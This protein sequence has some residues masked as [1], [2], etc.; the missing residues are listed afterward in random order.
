[1]EQRVM[2]KKDIKSFIAE[3]IK[4]YPAVYGPV[5]KGKSVVFD[6][7][8][9]AGEAKFSYTRSILPPKKYM[10]PQQ[11]CIMKFDMPPNPKAGSVVEFEDQVIVG[12]HPCDIRAIKL[13]DMIMKGGNPDDNYNKRRE[14]T[15][16]I[17]I[18]CVPDQYC[19]CSS[20]MD[21][22][23]T[24]GFDI[25]LTDLGDQVLVDVLTEKGKEIISKIET[26]PASSTHLKKQD[27]LLEAKKKLFTAKFTGPAQLL[28]LELEGQWEAPVWEDMGKKC[29]SCGQCVLVCP[30]CYCFDV[31]DE[32]ALSMKKGNRVRKWD[33]CQLAGFAHVGSGENFREEPSARVR[34]RYHR[35]FKYH[36]DSHST[37][38]CTGCGRC[39]VH[40]PVEINLVEISNRI[41]KRE[42]ECKA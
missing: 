18:D 42:A 30:T 5:A 6:R 24:E 4:L 40:C 26:K 11:E 32:L 8:K 7:L 25:F 19:Y 28:P 3:L 34:H 33:G 9:D 37:T 22:R 12:V 17:G 1:M 39:W 20:V 2:E 41:F 16:I 38:F 29:L 35:K 15:V 21:L 13:L 14:H 31:T 27:E 36:V 23:C 10:M